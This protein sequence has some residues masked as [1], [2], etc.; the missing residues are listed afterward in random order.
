LDHVNIFVQIQ[1]QEIVVLMSS[2]LTTDQKKID[3]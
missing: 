3:G 1:W 2:A